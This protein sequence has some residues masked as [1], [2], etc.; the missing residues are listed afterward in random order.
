MLVT[1]NRLRDWGLDASVT[2]GHTKTPSTKLP[3]RRVVI[4]GIGAVAP[5]GIGRKAF[6]KGLAEGK[7]CVDRISCFD[8]ADHP[9][10]L[11]AEVRDFDPSAYIAHKDV[12]GTWPD[13]V[14]EIADSLAVEDASL[15]PE[16][17]MPT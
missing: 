5:N 11:A 10:Q 14:K 17:R 1:T 6:W 4:T 9:S 12:E 2:V 7:N 15:Q 8:P 3:T 16:C 13:Y